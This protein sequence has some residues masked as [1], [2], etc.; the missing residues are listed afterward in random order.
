MRNLPDPS[1]R[2][3]LKTTVGLGAVASG[4][5]ACQ[6]TPA[7]TE[8][9][10]TATYMGDFAAEP[11]ATIRV[12]FIGTGARG[13]GHVAQMLLMEGVEVVAIC[14]VRQPYAEKSASKVVEAGQPAPAVYHSDASGYLRML[15][16]VELD[17]VIISTP[18]GLHA[19]MGIAAM[20]AGAHA[21]LEVPMAVTLEEMWGLVNT[22]EETASIA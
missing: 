21:F 20:Q 10:K 9:S 4:L 14:D 5:G 3:F 12:G 17:A 11:L 22:S 13:S 2:Q 18:W 7:A 8:R 1:R 15:E 19:P 6:S 16:E